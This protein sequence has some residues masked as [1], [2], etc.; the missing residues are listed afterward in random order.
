MRRVNVNSSHIPRGYFGK[1]YLARTWWRHVQRARTARYPLSA[2]QTSIVQVLHFAPFA[3]LLRSSA[4]CSRMVNDN[5]LVSI[6]TFRKLGGVK[7]LGRSV[8]LFLF[9]GPDKLRSGHVLA[10]AARWFTSLQKKRA[11]NDRVRSIRRYK[12]FEASYEPIVTFL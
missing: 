3:Q 2:A 8:S 10:A 9:C 12:C 11:R 6:R 7:K 4:R 1:W 5:T